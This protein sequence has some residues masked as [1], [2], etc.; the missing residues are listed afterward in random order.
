VYVHIDVFSKGTME[1]LT[2]ATHRL[3]SE[4]FK[5]DLAAEDS[6]QLRCGCGQRM[7]ADNTVI[8]HTVRFEGDSN[9]GDEDILLALITPCGHAGLLT[10][11]YGADAD[12]YTTAVMSRL[13][14]DPRIRQYDTE[15]MEM[16]PD[17]ELTHTSKEFTDE[18]VPP[19]LLRAHKLASDVW[20]RLHV[21]AGELQFC[22]DADPDDPVEL[23][24][25]QWV[26]I[27]PSVLHHV[28]PAPGAQFAIEFYRSNTD[29]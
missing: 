22:F 8:L 2:Q 10:S 23:T 19:A 17:L 26:D 15:Q 21:R 18:S 7:D 27:P 3:R 25:G 1:T 16:P 12:V 13:R 28:V 20:G 11:A 14:H 5:Y 4:G 6:A 24:A 9:P 29:R